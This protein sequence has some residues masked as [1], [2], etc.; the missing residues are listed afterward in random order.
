ME[1]YIGKYRVNCE[2]D[3]HN[4]FVPEDTFILCKSNCN[5]YRYSEDKLAIYVPSG[6]TK[7]RWMKEL[8]AVSNIVDLYAD[9]SYESVL[10]FDEKDLDAVAKIVGAKTSGKKIVPTSMKNHPDNK[11]KKYEI[12]RPKLHAKFK[13]QVKELG[14][15]MHEYRKFYEDISEKI[16]VNLSEESIK[17]GMTVPE[18]IDYANLYKKVEENM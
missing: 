10:L 3:D 13:E 11:R 5:I 16:G 7:K 17:N 6:A 12:Q 18:Y 9:D 2:L 4:E 14:L 1:K 15:K 8:Q